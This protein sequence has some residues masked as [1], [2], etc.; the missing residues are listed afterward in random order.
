MTKDEARR[1]GIPDGM[2]PSFQ[3]MSVE[4]ARTQKCDACNKPM[5]VHPDARWRFEQ[6]VIRCVPCQKALEAK[7]VNQFEAMFVS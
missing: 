6:H 4:E 1:I 7:G 3:H 5:A 2:Y